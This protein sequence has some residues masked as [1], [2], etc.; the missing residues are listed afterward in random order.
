MPLAVSRDV[1]IELAT[2]LTVATRFGGDL[3]N[4]EIARRLDFQ[5]Q[6]GRTSIDGG[7]VSGFRPIPENPLVGVGPWVLKGKGLE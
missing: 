5:S 1:E 3:V 6:D 4:P 2:I 7:A